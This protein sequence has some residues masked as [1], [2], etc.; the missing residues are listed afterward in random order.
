MQIVYGWNAGSATPCPG[1]AVE[2]ITNVTDVHWILNPQIREGLQG[3]D[4]KVAFVREAED[5]RVALVTVDGVTK[6]Q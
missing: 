3:L 1:G 4:L 5:V 6:V 2:S